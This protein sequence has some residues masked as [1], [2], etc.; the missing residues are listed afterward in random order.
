MIRLLPIMLCGLLLLCGC[1]RDTTGDSFDQVIGSRGHSSG[2]FHRPR[3]IMHAPHLDMIFVVDWDGR[4]QGFTMDGVFKSSWI[5]PE[6]KIGKPE[7]LALSKRN[8]ILVADTHYSRIVEFSTTGEFLGS[9]GSYGRGPGQFIYPVGLTVDTNGFIY[10]SEYGENDRIQKFDPDGR[11]VA[12]WGSFGKDPGQFQRPSGIDVGPDGLL[13]VADAVNHRIQVFT[14]DG[15]RVRI[16]GRQGT[17]PGDMMYPYDVVA[18]EN[19][20]YVLE[21][22]SQRVQK[23]SLEGDPISQFGRPGHGDG[24]FSSPWRFTTA[25]SVLYVSDTENYRVVKFRF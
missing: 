19:C 21:Y 18:T 24:Q 17:D 1:G 9:F 5:M 11:F 13:Y 6:V 15:K 20:L 2:K 10:V 14:T 7:D 4:I 16:I 22:G 3:G 23:L 12:E 25:D 8:T